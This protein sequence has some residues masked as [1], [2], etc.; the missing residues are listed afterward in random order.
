[1]PHDSTREGN[2]AFIH[3]LADLLGMARPEFTEGTSDTLL[4]F[5]RRALTESTVESC[6]VLNMTT[7]E[8]PPVAEDQTDFVADESGFSAGFGAGELLPKDQWPSHSKSD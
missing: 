2:I 7:K 4:G 3:G 1:M 8:N 5:Y 6:A